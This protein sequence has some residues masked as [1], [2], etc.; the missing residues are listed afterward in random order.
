[1]I[2]NKH[3]LPEAFVNFAKKDTYSKGDADGEINNT[4][5]FIENIFQ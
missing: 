2:T 3:N 5:N 4:Q 1:M